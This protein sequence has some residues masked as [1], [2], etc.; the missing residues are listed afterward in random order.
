MAPLGVVV[1]RDVRPIGPYR[2][3]P[4][5]RDGIVRRRGSALVRVV[6]HGDEPAIVGAWPVAGAVRVRA[7]APSALAAEYAVERMRFA[8]GLDH[9]LTPFHRRFRHDPLIGPFIRR[10]PWLRPLRR[11]E[12]FEALAWA[13]TE[14]LIEGG[15]A[16]E[17]QRKLIWRYG[18]RSAC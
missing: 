11:A 16:V 5:G 17:I 12:P 14:Q 2:M 15:R 3:P 4:A 9:D 6:H 1:E 13:I 7:E 10:Q 8:M 18:R